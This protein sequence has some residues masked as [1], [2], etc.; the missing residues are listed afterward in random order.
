MAKCIKCGSENIEYGYSAK[1]QR[2][3]QCAECK[4]WQVR[5]IPTKWGQLAQILGESQRSPAGAYTAFR[6]LPRWLR[7]W[8]FVDLACWIALLSALFV[9]AMR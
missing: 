6:R 7:V 4:A 8:F 1:Q 5:L 3:G 2:I 9:W